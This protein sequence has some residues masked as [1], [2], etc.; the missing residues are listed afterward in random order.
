MQTNTFSTKEF[1]SFLVSFLPQNIEYHKS[2]DF[3]E[4]IESMSTEIENDNLTI[5][6]QLTTGKGY[7]SHERRK[8]YEF[9]KNDSYF[10]CTERLYDK[11]HEH[12][13]VRKIIRAFERFL[14]KKLWPKKIIVS[15]YQE[16]D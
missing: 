8:E 2:F 12:Q 16:L 4:E 6:L 9:Q 13:L 14:D 10:K 7:S 3:D 15:I 1:Y 5:H 11:I